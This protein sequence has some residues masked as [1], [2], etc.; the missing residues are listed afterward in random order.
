[1]KKIIIAIDGYS[2]TGKSTLAKSLAKSLSYKY[3]DTGAMYRVV[4]LFAMRNGFVTNTKVN[5]SG[6]ISNLNQID[7]SFKLN[8][9]GK[10]EACLNAVSVEKEIRGMD[11]SSFVSKVSAIAEVRELLVAQQQ[12]MGKAKGVVMDGRDIGSVVFPQ[13]ELKLF[14][15]ASE[16]V[17]VQRRLDELMYNGVE[18]SFDAVKKNL[19]ERDYLDTNR[20]ISPLIKTKDALVL[21]N[22]CMSRAEQLSWILEKVSLKCL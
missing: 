20:A 3:I 16:E 13:A 11:V 9:E 1:M 14:M 8:A 4:T 19:S 15:T 17:R 7:I 22:S 12:L 21:D 10:S 6:L 2:S 5:S 18:V